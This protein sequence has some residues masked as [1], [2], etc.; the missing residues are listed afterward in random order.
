MVLENGESYQ[1]ELM[2]EIMK[3]IQKKLSYINEIYRQ[4][5]EID[6]ALSRDDKVSVQM[7]LGM[8]GEELDGL[9]ECE[10]KLQLL[11]DSTSEELRKPLESLIKGK[12]AAA[13][14]DAKAEKI[15]SIGQ[16]I[17]NVL[18]QTIEIDRRMSTRLAGEDSFYRKN[19]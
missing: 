18:G 10:R 19:P 9:S 3:L 5:R 2:I 15:R 7:L 4:T 12:T 13:G 11:L 17:A 8:R 6:E 16:N 1:D 14:E